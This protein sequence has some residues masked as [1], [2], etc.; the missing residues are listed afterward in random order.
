M[1][2]CNSRARDALLYILGTSTG[3]TIPGTQTAWM[4]RIYCI[5]IGSVLLADDVL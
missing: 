3:I 1:M 2:R 4:H 5:I